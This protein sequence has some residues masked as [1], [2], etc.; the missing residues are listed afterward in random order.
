[1]VNVASVKQAFDAFWETATSEAETLEWM[2][3]PFSE[4]R[5][6]YQE[7]QEL[8]MFI[9]NK[10]HNRPLTQKER[11]GLAS[12][13]SMLGIYSDNIRKIGF[14]PSH[15]MRELIPHALPV[16]EGAATAPTPP[17]VERLSSSTI[18]GNVDDAVSRLSAENQLELEHFL[19][20]PPRKQKEP[21]TFNFRTNGRAGE[22]Q[23]TWQ[24]S[25]IKARV[26][27]GASGTCSQT[28][29]HIS[30]YP[31]QRTLCE[32]RSR[33]D[34]YYSGRIETNASEH[35]IEINNLNKNTKHQNETAACSQRWMGEL[36]LPI[37]EESARTHHTPRKGLPGLCTLMMGLLPKSGKQNKLKNTCGECH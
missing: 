24:K 27:A 21:M 30:K 17:L 4:M 2:A 35:A 25:D 5:Q 11:L 19:C 15:F 18:G 8:P 33:S 26:D 22:N 37:T 29:C 23:Y 36:V 10:K 20:Y 31:I 3:I 1:M 32:T 28:G 13:H 6:L 9:D 16:E 7:I 34:R 14:N 12:V